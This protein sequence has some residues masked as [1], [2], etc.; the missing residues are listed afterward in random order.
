M[1]SVPFLIIRNERSGKARRIGEKDKNDGEIHE[2][3]KVLFGAGACEMWTRE[4]IGEES[5]DLNEGNKGI[6]FVCAAKE[7]R[8]V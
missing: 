4:T 6:K 2:T 7:E 3:V 5:S 1:R 8:E